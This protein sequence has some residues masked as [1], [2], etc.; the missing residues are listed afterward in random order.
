[1]TAEIH[2]AMGKLRRRV[3]RTIKVP[4][5]SYREMLRL[6][7]PAEHIETLMQARELIDIGRYTARTTDAKVY[8]RHRNNNVGVT[9][10][11][12]GD[13]GTPAMPRT[14]IWLDHFPENRDLVLELSACGRQ[15]A[16]ITIDWDEVEWVFR[17]LNQACSNPKQV[18]YLWP[19]IVGI[20]S[21]N[22]DLTS[23]RSQLSQHVIPASLP[24]LPLEVREKCK[25][26]AATVAMALM[27][28]PLE[29]DAMP[30][31]DVEITFGMMD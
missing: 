19:A 15:F 25:R 11:V 5:I 21:V 7:A 26:T 2:N 30:T 31:P 6:I 4:T 20:M 8:L 29:D 1:M 9:F 23:W 22:E 14:P 13:L 24:T 27:L 3:M 28:P 17:Y 12:S 16:D 10:E 18:R